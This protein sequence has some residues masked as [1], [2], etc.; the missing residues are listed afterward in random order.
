MY[1]ITPIDVGQSVHWRAIEP[2][3]PLLA[4]EVFTTTE[5]PMG[6][7]LAEDGL[8]L[9]APSAT[10]ALDVVIV[11]GNLAPRAERA[12]TIRDAFAS[13][14]LRPVAVLGRHWVG[15]RASALNL[16]YAHHLAQATGL[17]QVT[18]YSAE[19]HAPQ[20]LSL[21]QAEQVVNAVGQQ[22]QVDLA[23]KE[24]LLAAIEAATTSSALA[25]VTVP[26]EWGLSDDPIGDRDE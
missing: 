7:V 25:A 22:Y 21:A 10:E 23:Q 18:F 8:S 5:L 13:G 15:G 12:Q 24:S 11:P 14:Q 4:G 16:F 19:D 2:D 20:V 6:Q 1:A 17:T 26:I 3:W 9:R